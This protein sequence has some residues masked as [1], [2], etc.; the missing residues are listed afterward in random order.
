MTPNLNI[1]PDIKISL[2]QTFGIN[3][4]M[5]PLFAV[6]GAMSKG[7]SK[8]ID[9]RFPGRYAYAEELAKMGMEYKIQGD[10]LV[11]QGG[12]LLFNIIFDENSSSSNL[13]IEKL[14]CHFL[15]FLVLCLSS[16]KCR[17]VLFYCALIEI[18][19]SALFRSGIL[20]IRP[21]LNCLKSLDVE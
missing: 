20:S 4:D 13:I 10:F 3:S 19:N 11:I 5:Q 16:K 17:C 1:Q 2:K 15:S 9:L 7:E 6:F 12:K 8:I 21:Y 18:H 14:F